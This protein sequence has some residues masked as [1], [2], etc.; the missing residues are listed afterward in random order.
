MCCTDVLHVYEISEVYN[1]PSRD[2]QQANTLTELKLNRFF[3]SSTSMVISNYQI[4][5]IKKNWDIKVLMQKENNPIDIEDLYTFLW[6]LHVLDS[7]R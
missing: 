4:K 2:I 5:D 1:M 7:L 6:H 3:Y